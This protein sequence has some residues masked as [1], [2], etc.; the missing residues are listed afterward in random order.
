MDLSYSY[1]K[2]GRA[3]NR[4]REGGPQGQFAPGLHAYAADTNFKLM[5]TLS[6]VTSAQ[7]LARAPHVVLFNLKALDGIWQVC[8]IT[9]LLLFPWQHIYM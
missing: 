2:S 7:S 1:F 9:H 8:I 6:Y 5:H 3:A 4:D